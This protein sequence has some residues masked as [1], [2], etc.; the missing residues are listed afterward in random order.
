MWIDGDLN[1][2][3][4]LQVGH[5]EQFWPISCQSCQ[6]ALHTLS[7]NP[8]QSTWTKVPICS[9]FQVLS[10]CI[11]PFCIHDDS[12]QSISQKAL[13]YFIQGQRQRL[14]IIQKLMKTLERHGRILFEVIWSR[15]EPKRLGTSFF[16]ATVNQW[17]GPGGCSRTEWCGICTTKTMLCEGILV[18]SHI[19]LKCTR[20]NLYCCIFEA[21]EGMAQ[22]VIANRL[23]RASKS[24]VSQI[25]E[26]LQDIHSCGKLSILL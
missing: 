8:H 11:H 18:V 19:C 22:E 5:F 6:F 24:W 10:L 3:W 20:I 9:L 1:S 25:C 13:V 15:N 12:A 7:S 21:E 14:D 26:K 17:C 2:H 16:A 4:S 23:K